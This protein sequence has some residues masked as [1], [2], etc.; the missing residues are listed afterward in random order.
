MLIH[1]CFLELIEIYLFKICRNWAFILKIITDIISI[2]HMET[3]H[4]M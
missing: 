4:F 2:S 3:V 1:E